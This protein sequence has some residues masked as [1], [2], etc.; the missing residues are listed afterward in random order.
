MHRYSTLS[1]S[2]RMSSDNVNCDTG[3]LLKLV[4]VKDEEI[5]RS[6]ENRGVVP[7]SLFLDKMQIEND[8]KQTGTKKDQFICFLTRLNKKVNQF[9]CLS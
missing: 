3:S 7:D 4:K 6:Q 9:Q 8:I 5:R 1:P 2:Y